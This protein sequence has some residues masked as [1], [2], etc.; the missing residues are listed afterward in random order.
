[1]SCNV[2]PTARHQ[3]VDFYEMEWD[4][5]NP[6][7]SQAL[8]TK[9][10]AEYARESRHVK[11]RFELAA[12]NHDEEHPL[13]LMRI[14]RVLH[15]DPTE[16]FGGVSAQIDNWC[17]DSTINRLFLNLKY[18]KYCERVIPLQTADHRKNQ[19]RQSQLLR[20]TK[21]YCCCGL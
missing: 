1:M 16:S 10:T 8:L 11:A 14:L 3:I 21:C 2:S 15:Q 17:S 6:K 4:K 9:Y 13:V 5:N 12:R 19:A 20:M 18:N 7:Q